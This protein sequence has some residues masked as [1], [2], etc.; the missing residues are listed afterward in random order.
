MEKI[1]ALLAFFVLKIHL[2][3]VNLPHKGQ[4]RGDLMFSL[5]C[6]WTKGLINNHEAVDMGRHRA[7]YGVIVMASDESSTNTR[8]LA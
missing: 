8:L 5:T 6:A 3:P 4:W 2:S 7:H 1:S